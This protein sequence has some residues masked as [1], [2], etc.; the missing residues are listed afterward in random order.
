MRRLLAALFVVS[1]A[2]TPLSAQQAEE[3][4]ARP[5]A[6]AADVESLDAIIRALYDVISGPAGPR[7]WGRFR[8]LFAPGARLIP[9][10]R[11]Q[12]GTWGSRV[13]TP[14]QY[15]EQAGEWFST[16]AFYEVEAHRQVVRYGNLVH[17]F[18]T[19]E[20]RRDPG[21]DPFVRGINSIQLL[22]DGSRWWILTVMWADE[23][24]AGELP[25]EYLPRHH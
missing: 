16:N 6:A 23:N 21:E 14:E 11:G 2:A 17:A 18:S 22:N 12:D 8:S 5:E 10:G 13:W 24:S 9:T 1:L 20:S 7:D 15:S 4:A 19:Y 3:P 25:D